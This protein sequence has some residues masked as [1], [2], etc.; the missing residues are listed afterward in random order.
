MYHWA[1]NC[2]DSY[3]NYIKSKKRSKGNDDDVSL[4][5]DT[6]K[7]FVGETLETAVLDSGCTKNVC[8]ETWI[9]CYLETFDESEKMKVKYF[10]S[11]TSFKF[12]SGEHVVSSKLVTSL[13]EIAGRKLNIETEV[14]NCDLPLLLSKDAMKEAEMS[15][16]FSKDTVIIFGKTQK[17]LL[18]SS[19]HYC[20]S[21]GKQTESCMKLDLASNDNNMILFSDWEHKSRKEKHDAMLKLHR[22]FSHPPTKR[23]T[24][25]DANVKDPETYDILH[26]VSNSCYVCQQYKTAS[27]RPVVGLSL[28]HVFDE[29]LAIDLKEWTECSTK[30]L[31]LHMI[32]YANRYSTSSVIRSK[33]KE[34]I[35]DEIFKIWIKIS[36]YPKKILVDN[37]GEFDNQDF[38]DFCE[39]LNITMKTTAAESPWSNGMVERH[40]GIIGE[41]VTKIMHDVICSLDVALSWALSAKNSL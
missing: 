14:V 6:M 11:S 30:T 39:N 3:Y 4:Y 17:L 12:G 20:I 8:G 24:L 2:P 23:I 5:S 10:S 27:P 21:I 35:V 40:N 22:Q 28:A 13:L 32:D 16:D 33:R 29:T 34:V 31:F 38:C 19:D 26:D 7:H 1:K 37:G 18:T 36:G 9:Q 15:I 41:S 25:K